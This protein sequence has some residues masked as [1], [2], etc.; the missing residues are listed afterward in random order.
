MLDGQKVLHFWRCPWKNTIENF[1]E[2]FR[3]LNSAKQVNLQYQ[4]ITVASYM[5]T[6]RQKFK[7]I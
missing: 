4:G 1:V 6:L 2:V 7:R 5:Y 3:M